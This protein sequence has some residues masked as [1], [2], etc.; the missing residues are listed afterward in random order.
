MYDS[1]GNRLEMTKD[2]GIG[3]DVTYSYAYN[4][5]G[6]RVGPA[7]VGWVIRILWRHVPLLAAGER[8]TLRFRCSAET[9]K[10]STVAQKWWN[11]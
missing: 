4:G 2:D 5:F 3:E 1:V 7:G 9:N 10:Q 11:L 8:R 6:Q